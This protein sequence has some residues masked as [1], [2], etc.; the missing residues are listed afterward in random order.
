MYAR[1]D[2]LHNSVKTWK[3]S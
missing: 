3:E 2:N 1:L